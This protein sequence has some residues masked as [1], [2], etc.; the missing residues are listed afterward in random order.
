M[1]LPVFQRWEHLGKSL[2]LEVHFVSCKHMDE[3]K[4]M[5]ISVM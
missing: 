2:V 1:D 4:F 3:V 5:Q